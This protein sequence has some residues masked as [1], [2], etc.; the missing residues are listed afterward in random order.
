MICSFRSIYF[1]VA[2][3]V[4]NL[5]IQD[6]KDWNSLNDVYNVETVYPTGVRFYSSN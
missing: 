6:S 1:I 4:S 5:N 3:S 2:T